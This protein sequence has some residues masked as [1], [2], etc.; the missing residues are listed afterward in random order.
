MIEGSK[1]NGTGLHASLRCTVI[2]AMVGLVGCAG[3]RVRKD[4]SASLEE[5]V[6]AGARVMWVAAHPDDEALAGAVFAR[7]G[8][9]LGHPLY[10]LVLTHGDGGECCR[11]EGCLPDL[12]TV[13][14]EEM[15][16]VAALYTA[17]LQH[18]HYYNASLPVESFP[19]RHEI[20]EKW[21]EQG[22]PT[23]KIARAIRS[24]KPDVLLTFSPDKGFTGHPEHQIAA[25]FATAS[26]CVAAEPHTEIGGLPPF[27]VENTYYVLNRYWLYVLTGNADPGPYSEIFDARQDCVGSRKCRD[28]MAEFTRP[29]RSQAR[30]M[31]MVRKFKWMIDRLYLYRVDPWTEGKDPYE[32]VAHGGM[33]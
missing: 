29:H 31:G 23:V 3:A 20:A 21:R 11:P 10:F 26:V 22:D 19:P 15:K 17:E 32:P 18:E 8:S 7:V 2:L 27:R 9:T 1:K 14:G 33:H 24:F 12:T 25:R 28:V 13:R 4:A 5:L 16:E 6:D 30:D